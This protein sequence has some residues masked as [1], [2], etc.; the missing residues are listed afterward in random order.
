MSHP[1][2]ASSR[3]GRLRSL[4]PPR[5]LA[6]LLAIVAIAG[7]AWAL[8]VP[9]WQSPDEVAHFAYAQSLAETGR[10][11]GNAKRQAVSSDQGVA[12]AA[13]GAS[14]GAFYPQSSP[15]SWDPAAQRAYLAAERGR[16]RPSATNGGGPNP[17]STNPPFYYGFAAV[18]YLIDHGG[19]AFG[20]LYAMQLWGILLLLA[21]TIGGWLLAGEVFGRRRLAQV[22]CA[23]VVG[24]L[25]MDSFISTSVNPDAMMITTWTLAL[26][27]GARVI[28]HRGRLGDVAALCAVTAAA[29]LTKAT[30]YALVVPVALALLLAWRRHPAPQRPAA[31]RRVAVGALAL[32]LPVLGWLALAHAL[33]RRAINT[34]AGTAGPHAFNVGQFLSYLWQFYLPRLGFLTPLRETPQ[35]PVYDIWLKQGTGAFGWLS[36]ALPGWTYTVA[37]VLLAALAIAVVVLLARRVRDRTS[38]SLLGFFGLA[39][40]ALLGLLHITEYRSIIAGAGQILQGRYLLPMV[41]LLGL[42]V[43][44]VVVALPARWRAG[45][46]GLTL[47]GLLVIQTL[48]LTTVLHAYYL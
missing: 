12:D 28:N 23:A 42:G 40:L 13:V 17:A 6:A 15:P 32:I 31:L 46:C 44:L 29:I 45:A 18:G 30:S 10:L 16:D 4:A 5:P 27:L 26:W 38:L 11:P 48:S 36:V 37:G 2:Q 14:R 25:P 21:S 33:H 20:R 3:P 41:G 35:L 24:L 22:A 34:I 1:T 7:L 39:L 43:G 19:T 8:T 9:P 47:A